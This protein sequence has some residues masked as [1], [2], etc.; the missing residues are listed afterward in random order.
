[1]QI[2]GGYLKSRKINSPKGTNVRPTLSQIRESV[3]SILKSLMDFEGALFL[4]A[5][6]G[7]GIMGFEAVS[8]GFSY[9]AFVEN[10][11]ATFFNALGKCHILVPKQHEI[12]HRL[13]KTNLTAFTQK[14]TELIAF[15]S[16][17]ANF[18][19][20]K[21][22]FKTFR[23]ILDRIVGKIAAGNKPPCHNHSLKVKMSSSLGFEKILVSFTSAFPKIAFF[24]SFLW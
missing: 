2:T 7:S 22:F 21:C 13:V 16:D 10:S 23:D 17:E 1:M 12:R 11:D 20:F 6:A 14:T 15:F 24:M 4:D 8:R 9:A 3:F 19:F 18:L 5:F